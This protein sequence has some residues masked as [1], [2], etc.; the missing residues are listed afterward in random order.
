M[1]KVTVLDLAQEKEKKRECFST[2]ELCYIIFTQVKISVQSSRFTTWKDFHNLKVYYLEEIHFIWRTSLYIE[3]IDHLGGIHCTEEL[4]PFQS[5]TVWSE[6][7]RK[8]GEKRWQSNG[9]P[10]SSCR[11]PCAPVRAYGERRCCS[12][13]EE[14][15]GQLWGAQGARGGDQEPRW[16]RED[17]TFWFSKFSKRISCLST[18]QHF[19]GLKLAQ[20]DRLAVLPTNDMLLAIAQSLKN[21]KIFKLFFVPSPF[22]PFPQKIYFFV[23]LWSVLLNQTNSV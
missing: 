11:A 7:R 6:K 3:D 21:K 18:Y 8:E 16:V 10:S 2:V 17:A 12:P 14:V 23:N 22:W 4:S 15:S 13:M 5:F 20:N 1:D 19:L 9:A